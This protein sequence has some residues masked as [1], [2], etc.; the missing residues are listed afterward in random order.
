MQSSDYVPGVS[1]W[2]MH[3][4]G[5]LEIE[6]AVRVGV[7]PSAEDKPLPP[8]FMIMDGVVYISQAEIK[9][10]TIENPQIVKD[11]SVKT[12]PL[13]GRHVVS[14]IGMGVDSQFL[15]SADQFAINGRDASEILSEI[16][17][18]IS[19]TQLVADLREKI[20]GVIREELQPGGILHRK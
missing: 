2:K 9:R 20:K 12:V 4:D 17:S 15:V 3:K 1:G 7:T 5:R 18:M 8:P 16:S 13:N 11:W 10:G 19:E 14:G 6:G